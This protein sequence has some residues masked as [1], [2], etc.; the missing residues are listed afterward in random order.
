MPR[1]HGSIARRG[2]TWTRSLIPERSSVDLGK[3]SVGL[4]IGG[5]HESTDRGDAGRSARED[6]PMTSARAR[7]K[8]SLDGLAVLRA[9]AGGG[10]TRD[11]VGARLGAPRDGPPR[12]QTRRRRGSGSSEVRGAACAHRESRTHEEL[13]GS[14]HGWQQHTGMERVRAG[15][16]RHLSRPEPA[17]GRKVPVS[18]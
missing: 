10:A 15:H 16:S 6:H 8:P 13:V 14:G 7:E 12:R 9:V 17:A 5:C 18:T 1:R 4:D 2:L 11:G 3:L